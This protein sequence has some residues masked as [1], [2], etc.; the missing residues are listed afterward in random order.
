MAGRT[1]IRFLNSFLHTGTPSS[2][3]FLRGDGAW[4]NL[5]ASVE[6]EKEI[7]VGANPSFSNSWANVGTSPARFY[8]D[9]FGRVHLSGNIDTGTSGTVAFTLPVGYRPSYGTFHIAYNSNGGPGPG[10]AA[11]HIEVQTDGDVIPTYGAGTDAWLDSV[12]F[13]AA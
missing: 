7:G 8:K 1:F 6:D 9:P 10:G 4:A 5:L 12:S 3:T 13:R 11:V 2:E